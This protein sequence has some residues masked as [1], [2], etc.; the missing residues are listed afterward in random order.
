[1]RN[2]SESQPAAVAAALA[3]MDELEQMI[4]HAR[5]SLLAG[6]TISPQQQQDVKRLISEAL[7]R[8]VERLQR[9]PMNATIAKRVACFFALVQD[10]ADTCLVRSPLLGEGLGPLRVDLTPL[11]YVLRVIVC[12]DPIPPRYLSSSSSGAGVVPPHYFNR[13]HG[14]PLSREFQGTSLRMWP[15][16]QRAAR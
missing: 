9:Q 14:R 10:F 12:A 3:E 1:M 7:P 6:P 8:G 2:P 5:Q 4:H 11:L 13:D 15:D 16:D